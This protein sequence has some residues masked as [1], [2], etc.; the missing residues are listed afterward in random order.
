MSK[1]DTAPRMMPLQRDP[2]SRLER[3][4]ATCC[5][6]VYLAAYEVYA[7]VF[8]PQQAMIEG[9]CRGGFAVQEIVAFLYARPFPKEQ[10]H[11][12]VKE[13]FQGLRT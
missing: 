1:N 13:A 12:R 7:H 9:H 2:N 3:E 5:E 6:A 8:G 4:R 10:W 11:D